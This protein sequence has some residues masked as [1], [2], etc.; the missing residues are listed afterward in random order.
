[1]IIQNNYKISP[2][3]LQGPSTASGLKTTAIF[4]IANLAMSSFTKALE[5][6]NVCS[7]IDDG[8]CSRALSNKELFKIRCASLENE[9]CVDYKNWVEESDQTSMEMALDQLKQCPKAATLWESINDKEALCT[10]QL[11]SFAVPNGRVMYEI[12]TI[13]IGES[14]SKEDKL[15]WLL[16]E[17][18][19]LSQMQKI[20]TLQLQALQGKI[21]R[22][23]WTNKIEELEY[24]SAVRNYE[25]NRDCIT[26][27]FWDLKK[28]QAFLADKDLASI[29]YKTWWKIIKDTPHADNQRRQWDELF[30][31]AY[32][33]KNKRAPDCLNH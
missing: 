11:P 15:Y 8:L 6:Q 28:P 16:F 2:Y 25:M 22:E 10:I 27:K 14:L 19:N 31:S 32:C 20:S 26:G 30:K 23:T 33:A 4:L 12:Q 18:H 24:T 3:T 29:T 13:L 21:D 5:V 1:M 17:M 7:S 9:E